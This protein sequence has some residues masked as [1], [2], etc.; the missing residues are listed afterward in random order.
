[1]SA[2]LNPAAERLLALRQRIVG[3]LGQNSCYGALIQELRSRRPTVP[4]WSPAKVKEVK[5]KDGSVALVTIPDNTAEMQAASAAQK[6]HDVLMAI[7]DPERYPQGQG[8]E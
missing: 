2:K 4:Y 1:M 5:G 7:I 6:W 8:G 3:E